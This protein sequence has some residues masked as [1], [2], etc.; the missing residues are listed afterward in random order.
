MP[1]PNLT[2]E[3]VVDALDKADIAVPEGPHLYN[4]L[5]DNTDWMPHMPKFVALLNGEEWP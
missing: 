2:V 4:G 3:Q 1:N 5:T